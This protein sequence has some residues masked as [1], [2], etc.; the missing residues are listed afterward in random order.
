MRSGCEHYACCRLTVRCDVPDQSNV[1][2]E[3]TFHFV[4]DSARVY[5]ITTDKAYPARCA[6]QC[7]DE[8]MGEVGEDA[9]KD[10][11]TIVQRCE[12]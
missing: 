2:K 1:S 8:L 7:L 10:L 3:V 12:I 9:G 11:S 6:Y 5:I 4:V